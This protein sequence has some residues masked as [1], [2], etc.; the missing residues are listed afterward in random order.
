M[1]SQ[2]QPGLKRSARIRLPPKQYSPDKTGKRFYDAYDA[3]SDLGSPTN[4]TQPTWTL[5]QLKEYCPCNRVNGDKQ[6]DEDRQQWIECSACETYYHRQCI[7]VTPAQ[8]QK[9]LSQPDKPYLCPACAFCN[10]QLGKFNTAIETHLRNL[11]IK[12]LSA[13]VDITPAGTTVTSGSNPSRDN[14][15]GLSPVRDIGKKEDV[16]AEHTTPARHQP[17]HLSPDTPYLVPKITTVALTPT[18]PTS[19]TIPPSPTVKTPPT[20][21]RKTPPSNPTVQQSTAA[22]LTL[23]ESLQKLS[24]GIPQVEEFEL[25]V[26]RVSDKDI[27]NNLP[28]RG[29]HDSGTANIVILDNVGTPSLYRHSSAIK[30]EVN[31]T[32]PDL[33][34]KHAY[35]LPA[36]GICLVLDSKE[37]TDS[38]LSPWPL[39][40]FGSTKL[41]P[42]RPGSTRSKPRF[43]RCFHCQRFGHVAKACVTKQRCQRCAGEHLHHQ[44]NAIAPKC[45]NCDGPHPSNHPNCPLFKQ[46]YKTLC[47]RTNP[48]NEDP[49][50]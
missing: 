19:P 37:H 35:P 34:L 39:F 4:P 5:A 3:H 46:R 21:I 28:S 40:A 14:L 33:K 41:H 47:E 17:V 36:G 10:T 16:V 26:K 2:Q 38:A 8:Y 13:Q 24:V 42:H 49:S 23:E 6:S 44:C 27:E 1:N 25:K 9:I 29:S 48:R 12:T 31:R 45:A 30:H 7:K 50:H 11:V 15:P 22:E 32:K 18:A 20:V 43:I